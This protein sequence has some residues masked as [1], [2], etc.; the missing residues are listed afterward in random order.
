MN[1]GK[2]E[3]LEN[4]IFNTPGRIKKWTKEKIMKLKT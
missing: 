1:S 2:K 4:I 3:V